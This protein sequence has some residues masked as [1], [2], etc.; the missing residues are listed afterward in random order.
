MKNIKA[1]A[2]RRAY[3]NTDSYDPELEQLIREGRVEMT[4]GMDCPGGEFTNVYVDGKLY[5]RIYPS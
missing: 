1:E 5:R 4:S 2:Y 3:A